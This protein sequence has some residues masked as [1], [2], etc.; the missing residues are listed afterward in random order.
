MTPV[1]ESSRAS[2]PHGTPGF[3]PW[4]CIQHSGITQSSNTP[5]GLFP[6]D[7]RAESGFTVALLFCWVPL[8]ALKP[9]ILS[10]IEICVEKNEQ[11]LAAGMWQRMHAIT[12][13]VTLLSDQGKRQ[14]RKLQRLFAAN[15]SPF[16]GTVNT[17]QMSKLQKPQ[18]TALTPAGL[19]PSSP[20]QPSP[21]PFS[22]S[23]MQG[24][25]SHQRSWERSRGF[26]SGLMVGT[27]PPPGCL[28]G[29]ILPLPSIRQLMKYQSL[30]LSA[31][32]PS[33]LEELCLRDTLLT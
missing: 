18:G 8:S 24:K 25:R 3:Q 13:E 10:S 2:V 19:S 31:A 7:P 23:V 1:Q 11:I 32:Q 33:F 9:D 20:T 29:S 17:W 30:T 28:A 21:N 4:L 6:V 15:P 5:T 14:H 26:S 16:P 22:L 12:R 27:L